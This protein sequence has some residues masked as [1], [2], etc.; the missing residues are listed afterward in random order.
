MEAR[1][2][3]NTLECAIKHASPVISNSARSEHRSLQ[4]RL[5]TS[6]ARNKHRSTARDKR[7]PRQPIRRPSK[8]LC[9]LVDD[10]TGSPPQ[11]GTHLKRAGTLR[12]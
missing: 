8:G 2:G 5:A 4:A 3:P 12:G 11:I 10:A 7:R 1:R 6:T 9:V